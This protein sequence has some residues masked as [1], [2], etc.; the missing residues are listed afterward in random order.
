[1][2]TYLFGTIAF[3]ATLT[4]LACHPKSLTTT[5]SPPDAPQDPNAIARQ[6]TIGPV[7]TAAKTP[8]PVSGGTLTASKT[9]SIAVASDPDRDHIYV[10]DVAGQSVKFDLALAAG[11]QPS[12]IALDEKG[13]AYAILRGT[14]QLA[15]I[16]LATG[17]IGYRATCNTPRGVTYEALKDRLLVS[18]A[19]G[20]VMEFPRDGAPTQTWLG[21]G[22]D[23]RDIVVMGSG[24]KATGFRKA[25]VVSLYAADGSPTLNTDV[26]PLEDNVVAWRAR[27][28][29]NGPN[30]ELGT[31]MLVTTQETT[32]EPVSTDTGGYSSTS[33]FTNCTDSI[34]IVSTRLWVINDRCSGSETCFDSVRLP[35]AVLPVDVATNGDAVIVVAAGNAYSKELS[36][37]FSVQMS[38][39]RGMGKQD[40]TPTNLGNVDGQAVAADFASTGELLVQTREPAALAIM[41][42]DRQRVFKSISLSKESIAD[43][44]DQI[45]HANSGG[46]L[47]CAS[48]HAEGGDDSHVWTF[49]DIGPRR[50]P[51]LRGT[52]QG[53]APYH[54]NGDQKDMTDIVNHVFVKRMS[55]PTLDA[56]HITALQNYLFAMPAP[57]QFRAPDDSTTHGQTLFTQRCSSCH[58]GSKMTDNATVDVG[59]LGRFQVPSL[60]GVRWRGP[61]L[62]DGC[63][64]TLAKRFDPTC[65]GPKH[66]DLT[67]LSP[68]DITDIVSYL[69]TL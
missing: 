12:R 7:V 21:Q 28:F 54:W 62:H 40:C 41:T 45:F 67:G 18:C 9:S 19:V 53:T 22:D 3:G 50:T 1:M 63:A 11:A 26:E 25:Q 4:I 39:I 51:S 55:G 16:N 44:G 49:D 57:P 66:A 2:R 30:S 47:A 6:P 61:W 48:C 8:T 35:D 46:N 33:T 31:D 38:D 52:I 5:T 23:L 32:A 10:V 36:Q 27:T 14:N 68:A 58:A 69:E 13:F 17:A 29:D 37:L 60:V 34:G 64:D 42:A 24:V 20:T 56:P 65:G 43:T 59:T 15:T